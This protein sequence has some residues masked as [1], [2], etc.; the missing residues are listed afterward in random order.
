M[1]V[2]AT[3]DLVLGLLF[4]S[5]GAFI[6]SLKKKKPTLKALIHL[7]FISKAEMIYLHVKYY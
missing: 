7:K 1:G 6:V 5:S 2:R 4:I 3:R